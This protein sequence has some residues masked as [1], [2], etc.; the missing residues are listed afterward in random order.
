M[1]TIECILTRRSIRKFETGKTVSDEIIKAM[2]R[3]AMQAPSAGNQQVWNFIVVTDRKILEEIPKFHPHSQMLKEAPLAIVVCGDTNIEKYEGYWVQDCSAAAQNILLAAHDKGLG[4]V[5][6]GVHP[7]EER[8]EAL[9]K[10][11]LLP[12]GVIPLGIIAAGYAAQK[13]EP[14]DRYDETKIHYNKW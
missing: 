13:I 3:A 11:L 5:W 4:A 14:A 9:K 12:D 7:V 6:L 8:E 2:L 1:Q 10:L